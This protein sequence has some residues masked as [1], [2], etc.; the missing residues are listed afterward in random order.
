MINFDKDEKII[1]EVRKHW[2]VFFTEIFMLVLFALLPIL[3]LSFL[4]QSKLSAF[5]VN[6]HFLSFVIFA[7][8]AWLLVL[9][10][11]GFIFWTD[12]FLDVW[13]I[14][15]KKVLD[16][17]QHGF[18]R[19]EVSILHLDKIQDIT[20]EVDGFIQTLMNYGDVLVQTAGSRGEYR[21]QG[22]PNPGN[23]QS[24]LNEALINYRLEQQADFPG[25][26]SAAQETR[27]E[28]EEYKSDIDYKDPIE[29]LLKNNQ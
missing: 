4:D 18:F 22:V 3:I 2:L 20:F 27:N 12:Y 11:A 16:V 28:A 14:T 19:R 10:V 1:Y 24:K 6:E 23:V 9:W 13:I 17:E 25:R 26:F 15:N 7:Y 29:E 5:F 8:S 21:I